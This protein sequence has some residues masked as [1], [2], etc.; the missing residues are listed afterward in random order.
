MSQSASA[1]RSSI[2]GLALCP[3]SLHL[4]NTVHTYA[5]AASRFSETPETPG[6]CQESWVILY[7][8]NINDCAPNFSEFEGRAVRVDA[9]TNT[10]VL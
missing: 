5:A 10:L 2:C 6:L 7:S 1:I 9:N 3:P 4:V 8:V